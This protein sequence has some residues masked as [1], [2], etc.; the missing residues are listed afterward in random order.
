MMNQ[1]VD[2]RI[3]PTDHLLLHEDVEP[4]RAR[5]VANRI[6]AE[7]MLKN[8][9]VVA[10]LDDDG[11]FVVL[12]GANRATALGELGVRDAL[13]QVVDYGDRSVEPQARSR[14]AEDH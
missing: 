4:S 3:V 2:L 10:P 7:Q 1:F 11:Q 8:P 5:R 13:V 6:A 12:D 9:V 14:I